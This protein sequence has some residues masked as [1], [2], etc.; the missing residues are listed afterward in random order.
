GKTRI[1]VAGFGISHH[2]NHA[3]KIARGIVEANPDH[4]E[5]WFY[6]SS[7]GYPQLLA[8]IKGELPADQQKRFG[9]HRTAPFCWLESPE[10]RLDAKGGRDSFC[11]WVRDSG[12]FSTQ[13]YDEVRVDAAWEPTV[14][15]AWVDTTPGT[16]A[17]QRSVE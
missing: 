1:C 9:S 7:K 2:T 4:Y 14:F 3:G 8:Q 6:F 11:E 17:G 5:S 13:R 16:A 15:E 12:K 10:G